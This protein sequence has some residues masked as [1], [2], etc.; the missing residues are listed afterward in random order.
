MFKFFQKVAPTVA[1]VG[2]TL[3]LAAATEKLM[4]QA[5]REYKEKGLVTQRVWKTNGTTPYLS[6]EVVSDT[7][8][9][10]SPK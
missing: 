9:S 7:A 1:G 2:G 5:E 6:L 10:V 4:G 3:A 8:T